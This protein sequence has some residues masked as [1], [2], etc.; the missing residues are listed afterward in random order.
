[1]QKIILGEVFSLKKKMKS[2]LNLEDEVE[3]SQVDMLK[4]LFKGLEV[5]NC[6]IHLEDD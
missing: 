5:W 6:K 2:K 4:M 3:E 1:M